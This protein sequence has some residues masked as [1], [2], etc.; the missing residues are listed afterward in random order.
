MGE[1]S[2]QPKGA[3]SIR[4]Y[5]TICAKISF[6]KFWSHNF[7]APWFFSAF[8]RD[9][10]GEGDTTSSPRFAPITYELFVRLLLSWKRSKGWNPGTPDL[11]VSKLYAI[12]NIYISALSN[13]TKK[14]DLIYVRIIILSFGMFPHPGFQWKI[15]VKLGIPKPKNVILLVVTIA[16]WGWDSASQIML[17]YI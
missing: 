1:A 7:G 14:G 8:F 6:K 13:N 11:K 17:H 15:Q 16:S 2:L 10:F 9:H 3:K 4:D 12:I 5:P